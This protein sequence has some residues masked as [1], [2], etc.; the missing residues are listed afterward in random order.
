MEA[1]YDVKLAHTLGLHMIT[2]AKIETDRRGAFKLAKLLRMGEIPEAYI[3]PKEKRPLRDLLRR[4]A[5]LVQQGAECYSSFRVQ[6]MRYNLNTM[7]GSEMKQL[8][9]SDF[10]IMPIPQELKDYCVMI[11]QRLELLSNQIDEL[12]TY[13]KNVSLEDPKFTLLLTL[14]GVLYVLGLTIYYD[15]RYRQVRQRQAICIVLPSGAGDLAIFRQGKKRQGK[16]SGES[17]P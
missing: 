2:G 5:G 15:R 8:L 11:L 4:R 13:L 6:F 1:G 16:Q 17:L 10:D 3:Y 7:S 12:D 14:P 9:P